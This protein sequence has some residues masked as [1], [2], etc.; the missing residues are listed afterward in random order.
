MNQRRTGARRGHKGPKCCAG[1]SDWTTLAYVRVRPLTTA[2]NPIHKKAEAWA[3][4][5][6]SSKTGVLRKFEA[7]PIASGTGGSK[8]QRR[9]HARAPHGLEPQWKKRPPLPRGAASTPLF[10]PLARP[11]AARPRPRLR[12]PAGRLAGT[13]SAAP[14]GGPSVLFIVEDFADRARTLTHPPTPRGSA[15]S[16]A[17][18]PRGRQPAPLPFGP[19]GAEGPA[20]TMCGMCAASSC[21][22]SRPCLSARPPDAHA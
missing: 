1:H 16:S 2:S 11:R 4:N 20:S 13:P 15:P 9:P 19:G 6:G 5:P 17:P 12:C 21:P 8:V 7:R 3:F 14:R 18:R 22:G 10:C